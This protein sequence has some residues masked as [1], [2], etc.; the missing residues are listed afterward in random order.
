MRRDSREKRGVINMAKA[1]SEAVAVKEEAKSEGLNGGASS[2]AALANV[3]PNALSLV[4]ADELAGV[5]EDGDASFD[6]DGLNEVDASDVKLAALVFNFKGV[7][8]NGD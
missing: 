4:Q 7:D 3:A 2:G 1:K 8:A 6:V 5:F